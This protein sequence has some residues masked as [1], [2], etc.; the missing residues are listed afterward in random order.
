MIGPILDIQDALPCVVKNVGDKMLNPITDLITQFTDN[1][2][3]FTDC[4]GDQFV[5][6]LF[7]EIIGGIN[8]E[9][10]DVMKGVSSIFDGDLAGILR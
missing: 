9:L 6:A 10:G 1:V 5:G 7:N 2:Q 4:I 3:N 8:N